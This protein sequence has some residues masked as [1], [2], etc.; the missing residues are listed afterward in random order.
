MLG[1]MGAVGYVNV[2]SIARIRDVGE[3]LV[4][5][6]SATLTRL[7]LG[8]DLSINNS[9]VHEVDINRGCG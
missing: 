6:D 4:V 9:A 1:F 7:R 2:E 5:R 8:H 3:A